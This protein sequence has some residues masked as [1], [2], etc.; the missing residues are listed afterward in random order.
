MQQNLKEIFPEFPI[1]SLDLALQNSA[2][3]RQIGQNYNQILI[4]AKKNNRKNTKKLAIP[5]LENLVEISLKFQVKEN[6][7]YRN[8]KK[9]LKKMSYFA[10]T[11]YILQGQISTEINQKLDKSK[12]QI[13]YQ[14]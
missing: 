8:I 1:I 14:D 12:F 9:Q 6:S 7:S 5:N 11:N 13:I 10:P 2:F 3:V 4:K